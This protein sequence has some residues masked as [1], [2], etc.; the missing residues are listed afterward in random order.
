MLI[1]KSIKLVCVHVCYS[2]YII[3]LPSVTKCKFVLSDF[4]RVRSFV[5]DENI[6]YLVHV[7][8][9]TMGIWNIS[10]ICTKESK[11]TY[12]HLRNA[13]LACEDELRM[14]TVIKLADVYNFLV[15]KNNNFMISNS[16]CACTTYHY[17]NDIVLPLFNRKE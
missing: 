10:N 11:L 1:F 2:T 13:R 8:L 7:T 4:D 16:L 3:I 12:V 6:L 9:S 17:W 15:L 5:F 14:L